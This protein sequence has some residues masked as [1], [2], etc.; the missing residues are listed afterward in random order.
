L[1]RIG[2]FDYVFDI[3]GEW[4]AK[5]GRKGVGAEEFNKKSEAEVN[6]VE[7]SMGER[8]V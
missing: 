4:G 5:Y 8:V 7:V 2:C 1:R 3:W 6:E